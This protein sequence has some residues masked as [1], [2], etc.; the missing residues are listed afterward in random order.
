MA[1]PEVIVLYSPIGEV[2]LNTPIYPKERYEEILSCRNDGV[3]R[4]KY[5]VWKLLEKAAT[6]FLS[7]DFANL[8]FTKQPN[9]KWI[10]PDFYFSLSHSDDIV[11]VAVSRKSVGV[12]V[13]KFRAIRAGLADRILTEKE[14]VTFE[15]LPSNR[16]EDFIH[17][18]WAMKESL[19]KRDGGECLSPRQRETE[20]AGITTTFFEYGDEKYVLAVA[21]TDDSENIEIRFTEEI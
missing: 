7:L 16:R 17:S 3:K 14:L 9:G 13:Q 1:D 11:A 5:A 10:C 4:E 19:F 21:A 12:D 20:G 18:V 8:K 2:D 6:E 15:S